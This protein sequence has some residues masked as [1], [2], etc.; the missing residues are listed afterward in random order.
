MNLC[1]FLL[2]CGT[3]EFHFSLV[4][5]SLLPSSEVFLF[6]LKGSLEIERYAVP[7]SGK[8]LRRTVVVV[9]RCI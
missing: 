5:V 4:R 1:Y 7:P 6:L 9:V 8:V 3:A 2:F